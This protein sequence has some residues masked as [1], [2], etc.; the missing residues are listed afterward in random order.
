MGLVG[1]RTQLTDWA[2]RKGPAGLAEYRLD[3]NAASIDGIPG[4]TPDDVA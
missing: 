3:R 2:E 4:L 1:D